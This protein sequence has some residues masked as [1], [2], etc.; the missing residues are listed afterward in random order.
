MT[1]QQQQQR[2]TANSKTAQL[3]KLIESCMA[4]SRHAE[5]PRAQRQLL[6]ACVSLSPTAFC[7]VCGFAFIYNH[8]IMHVKGILHLL[9][10]PPPRGRPPIHPHPTPNPRKK[11]ML[12][13]RH[14]AK[15]PSV[16]EPLRALQEL[17]D[18]QD[19]ERVSAGKRYV[20]MPMCVCLCVS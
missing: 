17:L 18:P 14:G 11:G 8:S 2:Q 6:G 1:N 10:P 7:F 20:D 9:L 16:K 5:A 4:C 12:E 15:H 13:A 19:P 3:R